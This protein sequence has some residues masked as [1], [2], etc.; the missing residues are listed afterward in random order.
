MQK[1]KALSMCVMV[2]MVPLIFS[3]CG[4]ESP[5]LTQEAFKQ[6]ERGMSLSQVEG[7]LGKGKVLSEEEP[8]QMGGAVFV[9]LK[10]SKVQVYVWK[11]GKT[12][13]A[14]ILD[15]GCVKN[16]YAEIP[17]DLLGIEGSKMKV[18]GVIPLM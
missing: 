9:Q 17:P 6:I 11:K 16:A 5:G 18:S 14:V 13:I 4:A 3:G 15:Q 7:I 1:P 8:L 12:V 2:V 10:S